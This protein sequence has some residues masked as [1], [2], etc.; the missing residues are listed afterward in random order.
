M[1]NNM[2]TCIK[3]HNVYDLAEISTEQKLI[4]NGMFCSHC[5]KKYIDVE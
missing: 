2:N 5:W 4:D 1:A 3:C